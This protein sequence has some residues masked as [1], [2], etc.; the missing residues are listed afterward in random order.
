MGRKSKYFSHI[1][2]KLK[3][4]REW[5]SAGCTE[6]E[7][8]EDLKIS[9]NTWNNYKNKYEEF[10]ETIKKASVSANRQVKAALFRRAIGFEQDKFEKTFN[11]DGDLV[12]EKTIR[13]KVLP[14][15]GA[16]IF[17]LKNKL[18]NEFRDKITHDLE[19]VYGSLNIGLSPDPNEGKPPEE[20]EKK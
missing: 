19:A 5:I 11:A 17:W 18:P 16:I 6:K 2:P 9:H 10:S 12:K 7:I 14:D 3:E 20:K 4:I 13:E 15:V 8:Y 1:Q